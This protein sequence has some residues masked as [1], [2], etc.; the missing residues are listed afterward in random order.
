MCLWGNE[1]WWDWSTREVRTCRELSI[2]YENRLF[3]SVRVSTETI[4]PASAK[5]GKSWPRE[6]TA[7]DICTVW[8]QGRAKR[9]PTGS[10]GLPEDNA[11]GVIFARPC[12][13]SRSP[14]SKK[15][16]RIACCCIFCVVLSSEGLDDVCRSLSLRG[17]T[18]IPAGGRRQARKWETDE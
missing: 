12:A 18:T 3:L 4:W 14:P 5:F 17:G 8:L 16:C 6:S 13:R 15:P 11:A 9:A 2:A 10:E 7:D 1:T